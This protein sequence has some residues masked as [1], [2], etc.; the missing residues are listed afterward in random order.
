MNKL[1]TNNTHVFAWCI[2][3][4]SQ[5]WI[6][7][8]HQF[9]NV[10]RIYSKMQNTF[11]LGRPNSLSAWKITFSVLPDAKVLVMLKQKSGGKKGKN[12]SNFLN[13]QFSLSLAFYCQHF[14]PTSTDEYKHLP[15]SSAAE[16]MLHVSQSSSVLPA[17]YPLENIKIMNC[18][19]NRRVAVFFS[20]LGYGAV[21]SIILLDLF[22]STHR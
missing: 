17:S 4:W 16:K 3:L 8:I 19:K 10:Q 21:K 2:W 12:V 15:S 22:T 20:I 18:K 14:P 6:W 11:P 7:M 9:I 13:N 5:I 1:L